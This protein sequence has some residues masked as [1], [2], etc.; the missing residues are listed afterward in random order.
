MIVLGHHC[1]FDLYSEISH[2]QEKQRNTSEQWW[3][4]EGTRQGE[5]F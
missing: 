1:A 5:R 3:P 4:E 2:E